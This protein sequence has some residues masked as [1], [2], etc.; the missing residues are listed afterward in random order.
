MS[1]QDPGYGLKANALKE[2]RFI[3]PRNFRALQA[4]K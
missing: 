2:I 4:K 1:D 3:S